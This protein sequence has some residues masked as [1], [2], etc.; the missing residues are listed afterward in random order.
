MDLGISPKRRRTYSAEAVYP[1]TRHRYRVESSKYFSRLIATARRELEFRNL[2]RGKNPVSQGPGH[3]L[4]R[5]LLRIDH[6][7]FKPGF[8]A[9]GN[10]LWLVFCGA[11]QLRQAS[12]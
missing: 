3:C 10:L 9:K 7:N 1:P 8:A 5:S 4:L 6:T 2:R 11:Q 12:L